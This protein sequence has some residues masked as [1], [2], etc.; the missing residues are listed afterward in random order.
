MSAP[1][2]P[3]LTLPLAPGPSSDTGRGIVRLAPAEMVRLGLCPGETVA[4]VGGRRTHAR[5]LPAAGADGLIWAEAGVVANA[6]AR[7]GQPVRLARADLPVL[8]VAR[9]ACDGPSPDAARLVPALADLCLTEGDRVTLERAGRT[10][11]ISVLHLTPSPA[12]LVG[13]D[14]RIE[15]APSPADTRPYPGIAGLSEQIAAFHEMVE[16][17]LARPDLFDRL[18]LT[19]PRGVLFTGPPGSGKTLLAH[20]IAARTEAAFFH[21]A[22][23]E[24]VSKHYGESE[25]ALRDVFAAAT[26][27]APAIVFIDELDAIAPRREALSGEKQVERRVVGQLLTLLDGLA[28]RDQVVVVAAT[29][30][31][32]SLDPALRRPGRLERE[33][34]FRPPDREARTEILSLHLS[35]APL[36]AGVDLPVIAARCHGFVGADLAGLAR[37]AGLAALARARDEAGGTQA[38]HAEALEITQSDLETARRRIRPTTLRADGQDER[39]PRWS[40]I[41][42]LQAAKTQLTE[43]VIWPMTQQVAVTGLG[44]AAPR[45]I[46]LAGPP[47]TGKTLLV[48]ALAAEAELNF[49]PMRP[50]LLL[51]QFLG[52]AERALADAFTR[53]RLAAPALLFF[54]EIDALA[55]QRGRADASVDRVVAELLT[56]MDGLETND[57]VTVVAATNR[58]DALDPALTRPG[59]FDLVIPVGLPD[60]SERRDVLAVHTRDRPLAPEIDLAQ[61]ARAT[62]GASPADLAALVTEAARRALSRWASE[63]DTTKRPPGPRIELP[64]IDAALDRSRARAHTLA[65]AAALSPA[66]DGAIS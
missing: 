40:D 48:R 44:L 9:L 2:P 20:A 26:R 15:L 17:P 27:K 52:E 35:R 33:I 12:G 22:G 43:A 8:S 18:G 29:N 66:S 13:G 55:P 57:G 41:G 24:I 23:P 63:P 47:G 3:D 53:A 19:P 6:R 10:L 64:D 62:E 34:P 1:Q 5:L 14:T 25:R 58:P 39:P 32:N 46:L 56:Q 59:R 65:G 49:L 45:G 54:D 60:A 28:P 37:E 51:S 31:P 61:V 36:A 7:W 11:G 38:L 30:L 42:G 16:L 50:A 21:I 4:L